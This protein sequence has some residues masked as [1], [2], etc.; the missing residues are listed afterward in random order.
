MRT[1]RTPEKREAFLTALA[2]SGNVA[3]ASRQTGIA[4][5]ALYL[6]KKDDAEF[7]AEW[8][9]ALVAGGEHLEEEAIRRARNGWDEPA[10]YKGEQIGTVRKYSDT[11]LIFL[12]KGL[13]PEKYGDRQR[14]E[15]FGSLDLAERLARARKRAE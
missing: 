5:N 11:L 8:E 12:L 15:L 14:V 13:T 2:E 3:E 9:A 1:I 7:S 4:R 10:W 6:W